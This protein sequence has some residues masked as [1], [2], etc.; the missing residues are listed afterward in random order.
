[1]INNLF[2]RE[3]YV[4]LFSIFQSDKVEMTFLETEEFQSKL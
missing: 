1:M 2:V 3:E 4:H